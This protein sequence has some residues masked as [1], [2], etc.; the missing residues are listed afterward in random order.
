MKHYS[1]LTN[2]L[3]YLL[4]VA[5]L[6]IAIVTFILQFIKLKKY[7]NIMINVINSNNE[8][9]KYLEKFNFTPDWLNRLYT[10]QDIPKPFVDF[11]DDELY[12]VTMRSLLPLKELISQNVLIDVCGV[13]TYRVSET[14]YI[15]MLTP[16]CQPDFD[17]A[18]KY[19]KH[20][21]V[22]TIIVALTFCF[23]VL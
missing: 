7:T 4:N 6:P 20:S 12:D 18:L 9:F 17:M 14:K 5:L 13:V 1:R 10:V 19:I 21:L 8:F 23:F 15:V 2:T 22:F 3:V 16:S 11:S